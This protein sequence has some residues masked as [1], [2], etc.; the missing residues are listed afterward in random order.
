MVDSPTHMDRRDFLT[1]SVASIAGI[2]V[3]VSHLDRFGSFGE[4]F[5][6]AESS[7]NRSARTLR[8]AIDEPPSTLDPAQANLEVE[9]RIARNTFDT[10]LA[11]NG[12]YD[13]VPSLCT[14]YASNATATEWTFNLR[15]GVMFHDGTPFNSA[16]VKENIEYFVKNAGGLQSLLLPKIVSMDDSNPN[17]FKIRF[18]APAAYLPQNATI[19]YMVSPTVL[20][21]GP[22]AVAKN[23][24]G[25]GPFSL[26]SRSSQS[27]SLVANRNYWG[28]VPSIAGVNLQVVV[29]DASK[30][31]ALEASEL[32]VIIKIP[33]LLLANLPDGKY[34]IEVTDSIRTDVMSF[35]AAT[36]PV[37]NV[38]L[39][40]AI[41]Y[42]VDT[43]AIV[44]ADYA[45][46]AARPTGSVV[47]PNVQ[48]YAPLKT[49]Y[50]YDPDRARSLLRQAGYSKGVSLQL[51]SVTNAFEPQL[52]PET[53]AGQLAEI[54]INVQVNVLDV[55][56]WVKDQYG[57]HPAPLA[58]AGYADVTGAPIFMTSGTLSALAHY[59]GS[60]LKA[61]LAKINSSPSG[62]GLISL[63]E[64]AAELYGPGG[65]ALLL[66]VLLEPANA[67][68]Q[69]DVTGFHVSRDTSTD[70]FGKT[71]LT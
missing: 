35:A 8:V 53:I 18:A 13:L 62:P 19:I 14:S 63:I 31:D 44:N 43:A 52:V 1:R 57:P 54:G 3:A 68:L 48:G 7:A 9:F 38:L 58:Y 24:I 12:T 45:R 41:L 23:P 59:T 37:D 64:R 17:V 5:A 21:K 6:R 22:K 20:A 39:R 46:G 40:R 34:R 49:P 70:Y 67:V 61:L 65:H 11:Y 30:V 2:S 33:P 26:A 36:P 28:G 15:S 51:N 29:Q 4:P 60:D 71:R 42:G 56:T 50:R 27:V 25:S 69:R 10:L 55:A 47:A 16:A 66:P 32:D